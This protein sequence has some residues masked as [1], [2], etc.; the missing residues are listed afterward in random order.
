MRRDLRTA[1]GGGSEGANCDDTDT[2][3][4]IHRTKIIS[5]ANGLISV[6]IVSLAE[7]FLGN[8]LRPALHKSGIGVLRGRAGDDH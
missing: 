3:P 5:N 6:F 8:R 2:Q 1:G 4:E 7:N